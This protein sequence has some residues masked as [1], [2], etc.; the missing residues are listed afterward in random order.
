MSLDILISQAMPN[1]WNPVLN[2]IMKFITNI[3]SP[4]I[5][6]ILVF[7][8]LWLLIYKKKYRQAILTFV[9][10]IGGYLLE[11]GLKYLVHR[12]RPINSLISEAEF[13]FPSGHATLAAIYFLLLIYLFKDEIADK[14][15]KYIL[16]G[17]DIFL[18][19]LIGFSRI[20]LNVHWFTDVIAGF[21]LGVLWLGICI[22]IFKKRKK[23]Q[24]LPKFNF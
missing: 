12:T 1:I 10:V 2:W 21:V 19:L 22:L 18:I 23:K 17:V 20:Y 3:A 11:I 7:L 16:I 24:K 4:L 8:L 9:A 5:I 6:S 13:S 14:T 15:K